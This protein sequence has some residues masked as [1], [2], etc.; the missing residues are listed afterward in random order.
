MILSNVELHKAL[1]RGRLVIRPEPKPRVPSPGLESPYD[2]H[3]VDL[4][5]A[6]QISIP[7]G[8]TFAIDLSQPG[9]IATFIRQNSRKVTLTKEQPYNLVPHQFILG[10]TAEYV[11]LPILPGFDTCLAARIEGKSSRVACVVSRDAEAREVR[12]AIG[13]LNVLVWMN[14]SH[15][16]QDVQKGG[17]PHRVVPHSRSLLPLCLAQFLEARASS[18]NLATQSAAC[19]APRTCPS[20][21]SAS[22]APFAASREGWPSLARLFGNPVPSCRTDAGCSVLAASLLACEPRAFFQTGRPDTNIVWLQLW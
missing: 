8:G 11:E 12:R 6:A 22:S 2:T 13:D 5:L 3:S 17:S 1:D 4:T 20:P 14:P 16:D 21:T 7:E 18:L 19:L 10:Q 9:R 15:G